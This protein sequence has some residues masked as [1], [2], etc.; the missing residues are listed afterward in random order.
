MFKISLD[1]LFGIIGILN[2][3]IKVVDKMYIL[4]LLVIGILLFLFMIIKVLGIGKFVFNLL[5][6]LKEFFKYFICLFSKDF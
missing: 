3:I 2:G 5:G 1:G 6:G 4:F